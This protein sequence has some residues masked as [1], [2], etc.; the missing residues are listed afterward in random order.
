MALTPVSSLCAGSYFPRPP[1]LSCRVGGCTASS[2][3]DRRT[4]CTASVSASPRLSPSRR[5]GPVGAGRHLVG[6]FCSRPWR[7]MKAAVPDL[8][9]PWAEASSVPPVGP[10]P[11]SSWARHPGVGVVE[12]P[13]WAPGVD[14]LSVCLS[15]WVPCSHNDLLGLQGWKPGPHPLPLSSLCSVTGRPGRKGRSRSSFLPLLPSLVS[16]GREAFLPCTPCAKPRPSWV[17]ASHFT[18][19]CPRITAGISGLIPFSQL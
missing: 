5:R 3:P 19:T 2:R 11:G 15:S 10:T 6:N 7:C 1:E 13:C 4:P 14:P 17:L 12:L 8:T 18:L 16:A 9:D